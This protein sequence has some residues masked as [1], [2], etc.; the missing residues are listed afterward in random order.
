MLKV[1]RF[2]QFQRNIF[3]GILAVAVAATLL[4]VIPQTTRTAGAS[5]EDL[6]SDTG[7][8]CSSEGRGG[9]PYQMM[10]SLIHI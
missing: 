9:F 5:V 10:L 2:L 3:F 1:N 6:P 7:F 8:T 4:V